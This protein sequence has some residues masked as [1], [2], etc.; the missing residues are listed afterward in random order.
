MQLSYVNVYVTHLDRS[1]QFF[2]ALGL[3]LQF[4][5]ASFGY[6][7]LD[8]GPIRIGLAQID[9]AQDAI[10]VAVVERHGKNGNIGR[11]FVTGF[12]L[13]RSAI[14]S[15]VGHDSHNITVVGADAADMAVAVNRLIEICGGLA[16]ASGGAV[17]AE[18]ALPI[19]GL[20]SP[21]PFETV[22]QRLVA[23]RGAAAALGCTLP[24]PLLQVAFLPL[25]VI[26]H[27][28][29]TDYG[30]FDVDKFALIGN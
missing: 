2:E 5:D 10:R 15:S 17:R 6:A 26:P 21:E 4:S 28:K 20:M 29:I 9:L 13:R 22:R 3:G 23:L 12:G 30:L 16:V 19:S 7:S 18:L 11:G 8:A 1:V 27:L 24:E 14:A 25:P